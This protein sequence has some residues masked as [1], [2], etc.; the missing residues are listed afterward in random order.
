MKVMSSK[1][2]RIAVLTDDLDKAVEYHSSLFGVSFERT[3]EAVAEKTGV[4]V[5][6]NW[7]LGIE[8]VSPVPG[9]DNPVAKKMVE[10]LATRGG[11][12]FAAAFSSDDIDAD[13]GRFEGA[14]VEHLLTTFTFN[15]Q[16]LQDEFGGAFKR[17]EETVLDT[18]QATG[19]AYALNVIE[20]A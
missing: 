14:G 8:I 2:H 20:D 10:H 18:F 7:Q 4:A 11:G 15:E 6:V 3:G 13:L 17:F 1:I 19:A 16:Q 5:A 12:I 9:S